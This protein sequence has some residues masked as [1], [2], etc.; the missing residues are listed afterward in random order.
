MA[1]FSSE[2]SNFTGMMPSGAPKLFSGLM[3]SV[4][5]GTGFNYDP[6][7]GVEYRQFT[8][9]G[10]PPV[11]AQPVPLPGARIKPVIATT[12]G[13]APG[14][15]PFGGRMG[16]PTGV[17]YQNVEGIPWGTSN[18]LREK[19][20]GRLGSTASHTLLLHPE[21]YKPLGPRNTQVARGL[22][23][24]DARKEPGIG[25]AEGSRYWKTLRNE[26]FGAQETFDPTTGKWTP[27]VSLRQNAEVQAKRN[28]LINRA[29][30][31][32]VPS[33]EGYSPNEAWKERLHR[34]VSAEH[35]PTKDT[36]VP[37]IQTYE[38]KY[39]V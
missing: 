26:V 36:T 39:K 37:T 6:S 2:V 8:S 13:G 34:G 15:G 5:G 3:G 4:G 17:T 14:M 35:E 28:T 38:G 29:L 11:G 32:P 19:L 30:G 24:I 12:T 21:K 9:S 16:A 33:F 22:S 25:T 7:T 10:G 20:F 27:R 18:P 23:L 1:L 31:T